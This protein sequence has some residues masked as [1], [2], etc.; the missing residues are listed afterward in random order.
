MQKKK[1][2]FKLPKV[3]PVK[4]IYRDQE[5]DEFRGNPLL[6]TLPPILSEKVA[7]EVLS[8]YP[9]YSEDNM[10]LPPEVRIQLPQRLKKYFQPF[11]KH[12]DLERKF[13]AAL[14]WGYVDR[15]PLAIQD[16]ERLQN[17]YQDIQQGIIR[18]SVIADA[19]TSSLGLTMLGISG[20]G[21]SSALNRIISYYPQHIIHTEYKGKT[22]T[23]SQLTWLKLDCPPD[24]SLR[25]LC[26]KFF[27]LVDHIL[28][29]NY[30]QQYTPAKKMTAASM[31][32]AMGIIAYTHRLGVLVIDEIQNLSVAHSG[33]AEEM[34]NWFVSLVNEIGVPVVLIGT[35]KAE[36]ILQDE[37]RKA[38]RGSGQGDLYWDRIT[39]MDDWTLLIE[40]MWDYQWTKTQVPYIEEFAQVL[41]E[42]SQGIVDIAIK[43]FMLA[44]CQAIAAGGK[45]MITPEVIRN[46]SKKSL[47]LVKPM[48][49]ALKSG[50]PEKIALYPDI[51]PLDWDRHYD[52]YVKKLRS[53]QKNTQEDKHKDVFEQRIRSIRNQIIYK[54][55]ELDIQSD[56]AKTAAEQVVRTCGD[57]LIIDKAVAE[58]HKIALQ[59]EIAKEL[60]PEPKR[61]AT[62]S[63]K[64]QFIEPDL[65][66]FLQQA[67]DEKKSTYSVLKDAGVIKYPFKDYQLR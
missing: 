16:V 14:R 60:P 17:W 47:R 40:G 57:D 62:K 53:K 59:L 63:K 30:F 64:T 22:L 24:G 61:K 31:L 12:F 37:F 1:D 41:Y 66:Y 19:E 49:E 25:A 58:A 10:N 11:I 3:L 39:D 13:S 50:D 21:K 65:R 45:E 6:E 20:I 29:T 55:L 5:I 28:G 9:E 54:L 26:L 4:A 18:P 36:P 8:K 7:I 46:V 2:N 27:Q 32:P 15:N 48:L 33:G 23:L 56:I 42:E 34:L 35:P 52:E 43:L 67:K 44:Q 38:R 51:A